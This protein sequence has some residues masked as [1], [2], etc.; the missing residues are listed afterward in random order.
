MKRESKKAPK[1]DSNEP[2]MYDAGTDVNK[3]PANMKT[4]G[5]RY[6]ALVLLQKALWLE[7]QWRSELHSVKNKHRRHL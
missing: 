5:V 1:T 2:T 3:P 6:A 4:G 7:G